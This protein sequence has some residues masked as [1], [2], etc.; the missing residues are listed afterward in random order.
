MIF[1]FGFGPAWR[2]YKKHIITEHER[3]KL[4][5]QIIAESSFINQACAKYRETKDPNDWPE[6]HTC[7]TMGPGGSGTS[8]PPVTEK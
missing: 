4:R 6:L 1:G 8:G 7:K 5:N 3:D 2:R